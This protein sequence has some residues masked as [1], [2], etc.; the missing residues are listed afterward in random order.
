MNFEQKQ[1]QK[2]KAK[3]YEEFD[4]SKR[5]ERAENLIIFLGKI[6]AFEFFQNLNEHKEKIDFETFKSFL[7]RLNGIARDIP[8][9]Q[10]KFDGKNVEVSGG[11]LGETILPPR[12]EDKEE[13]LE[14]A[15]DSAK[16][17]SR[18]DDAY[19]IPAVVNALHM[20]NDGNG[21]TSRIIHL[22]LSCKDK[23]EFNIKLA[24]ALSADGRF[25]SPDINPGLIE[26]EIEKHILQ[27]DYNW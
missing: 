25:D 16:D 22:L 10:R 7:I 15:F 4:A 23:E 26:D 1:L 17:L 14:F 21:R 18:E 19:M 6:N 20:F 13:I 3:E 24:K 2:E 5:P 11:F 8:I 27:R 9:K 12:E